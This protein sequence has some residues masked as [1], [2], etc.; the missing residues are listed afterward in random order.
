M[1]VQTRQR[2]L[3]EAF[4][5]RSTSGTASPS[6]QIP[7]AILVKRLQESLTRL[8]N[9]E[10]VTVSQGEGKPGRLGLVRLM[11]IYT[12]FQIPNVVQP[13]CSL[14]NSACAWLQPMEPPCRVIAPTLPCQSTLSPP[15]RPCTTICALE[16][17]ESA[18]EHPALAVFW[19][20]SL[21]LLAY[22]LRL[23]LVGARCHS[24]GLLLQLRCHHLYPHP[25]ARPPA[26]PRLRL[27]HL[28][29]LLLLPQSLVNLLEDEV[30]VCERRPLKNPPHQSHQV[31]DRTRVPPQLQRHQLQAPPLLLSPMKQ[32]KP[33]S[34]I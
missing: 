4:T 19:L 9:F 11:L 3:L 5:T 30:S 23:Y 18:P 31:Q 7:L 10:V 22:H 15:S 1:S 25:L 28:R 12:H 32:L 24:L 33:L 21:P 20:L 34:R 17:P 27:P 6:S 8:E 16:S 2:F 29:R 13:K 14:D 26:H